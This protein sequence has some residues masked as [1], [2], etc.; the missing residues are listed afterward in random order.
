M[1]RQQQD[2]VLQPREEKVGDKGAQAVMSK[3]VTKHPG[4]IRTAINVMLTD[5]SGRVNDP[6]PGSRMRNSWDWL[7]WRLGQPCTCFTGKPIIIF[8]GRTR[9]CASSPALC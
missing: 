5:T 6:F 7:P 4:S 3:R 2:P 1:G 8:P 9:G